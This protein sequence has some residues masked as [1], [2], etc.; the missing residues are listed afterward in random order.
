MDR[1]YVT[2]R[3]SQA[4]GDRK[5][6]NEPDHREAAR[7]PTPEERDLRNGRRLLR[8]RR[9]QPADRAD[10][11]RSGSHGHW[12]RPWYA[13]GLHHHRRHRIDLRFGVRRDVAARDQRRCFVC[14]RRSR[15]RD[16]VGR[17]RR[18][19]RLLGV[20]DHP[21]RCLR[22][23]RRC[24]LRRTGRVVRDQ[25]QV[26]GTNAPPCRARAGLRVPADRDRRPRPRRTHGS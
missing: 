10:R 22:V 4:A 18:W 16:P 13:D 1:F 25:R 12:Q 17:R 7:T 6:R 19:C 5:A 21:G 15:S 20:S 2:W 24:L 23:L 3:T 9:G 26:V 8:T 14:V 11:C